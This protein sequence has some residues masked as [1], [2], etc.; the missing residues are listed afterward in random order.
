MILRF[1]KSLNRSVTGSMNDLIKFS[2]LW[3]VKDDRS[4]HDVGFR[5]NGTSFPR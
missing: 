3:L 4:P 2:R 5:L 1:S